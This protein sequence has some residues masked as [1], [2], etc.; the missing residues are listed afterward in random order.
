MESLDKL[1]NN[2]IKQG[3]KGVTNILKNFKNADLSGSNGVDL[4]EF[5]TVIQN[6]QNKNT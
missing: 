1:R 4:D 2:I 3:A 6:V 5:I